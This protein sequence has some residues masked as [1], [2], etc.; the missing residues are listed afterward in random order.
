M[1]AEV[2]L[3]MNL[4]DT[5]TFTYSIKQDQSIKI[6]CRVRIPFNNRIIEGIVLNIVD[7]VEFETKEIIDVIDD[8]P[9][10]NDEMI[11]LGKYMSETYI[12]SLMSCYKSMLPSALKFSKNKVQIKSI[13]YIW[14]VKQSD[15]VS[16]AEKNILNKLESENK[17]LKSEI[18]NKKA[19]NLLL[20]K[21]LVIEKSEEIYRLN[22]DFIKYKLNTLTEN[23]LNIIDKFNNSNKNI[24]LLRGIT[25][26]G[27]TEIYINLIKEAISNK[28]TAIIL[29]P[30]ISLTTQLINRFKSVFE[31]VAIIHSNLSE[32]EKYDEYRKIKRQE[33]DI[34]IGARSAVFAP[35]NNLGIIIIDEEHES[36]YKQENNPRYDTVDIAIWRSNYNKCKLLLGSA[37]PSLESYARAK[38]NK[39][40]LLELL[41][42]INKKELPEVN[43]IDM[44]NEIKKRNSILSELAIKKIKEKLEKK[45]Q[46]MVLLNRRGYSNYLICQECS[47]VLKCPNCDISLTYHKND[48]KMKCHYCDYSVEKIDKCNKCGSK[49][50]S[51]KGIG[52]EKIEELLQ[53]E[54]KAK[55]VRMDKDTTSKKNSHSKIIND[56]NDKKYDILLGTQMIAKGLD[57]ENVTLVIILNSDSS[58]NI[59]DFKS[60][61]K[62]FQLLTQASGRAGRKEKKG[63]IIIQTFNPTHYSILFAKNHDYLGFFNKE[64][65][66]RKKLNYPPFCLLVAVRIITSNYDLGYESITKIKNYLNKNLKETVLGPSVSLKIKNIYKFQVII[67][68]KERENV[69]K[70]LN[71]VYKHYKSSKLKLEVDFNPNRL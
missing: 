4:F 6:G 23:Q 44:K 56:F 9:L 30:E 39:Y 35:L 1:Y 10:L 41:T 53:N 15:D 36:S 25:G 34:V 11:E 27:K 71:E 26:S 38:T 59:P 8:E 29:V 24:N 58:L 45:E 5:K 43:I 40:N 22:Q 18:S 37:T 57:F 14:F 68:Y 64:I 55:V 47:E 62:T 20:E 65:I 46:I 16:K 51:L 48:N 19:L 67:K 54:F 66:I 42:R 28:K 13:K 60:S 2:L 17:I 33:V 63:E 70:I 32:S 52:T 69:Y 21:K 7:K 31:K 3:Q 12:C 49:Y 50:L 61:E